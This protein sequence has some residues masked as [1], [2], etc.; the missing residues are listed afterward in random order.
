MSD[1]ND[2][3]QALSVN[4]AAT[5]IIG[6]LIGSIS[7]VAG[8]AVVAIEVVN[9]IENQ[10]GPSLGDVEAALVNMLDEIGEH[11]RSMDIQTRITNIKQ[12]LAPAVTAAVDQLPSN[13]NAGLDFSDQQT[14]IAD[15]LNALNKLSDPS[16]LPLDPINNPLWFVFSGDPL[17]WNDDPDH[18][19][20]VQYGKTI[21]DTVQ[22]DLG[23]SLQAP[24]AYSNTD[25]VFNHTY[26]LISYLQGFA[27]L[28]AVGLALQPGFATNYRDSLERYL[29]FLLAVH[30]QIV[31]GIVT[32]VP[33][34]RDAFGHSTAVKWTGQSLYI[35]TG[36]LTGATSGP[37]SSNY[38]VGV[39]NQPVVPGTQMPS[40]ATIEYGAIEIYSGA[41]VMASYV[42]D[43]DLSPFPDLPPA[44]G[45]LSIE[46]TDDR[47]YRKFTLRAE[48]KL[49]RV[50]RKFG[51]MA[52]RDAI[53]SGRRLLGK[54]ALGRPGPGDWSFRHIAAVVGPSALIS[55][56]GGPAKVISLKAIQQFITQVV[57]NDTPF[58]AEMFTI[59]FSDILNLQ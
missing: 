9:L 26:I 54:P 43:F 8:A 25:Q 24:A 36:A 34:R 42:V 16:Q 19:V 18:L 50:Y 41:S 49:H 5:A 47:P 1:I 35:A 57:P 30:D 55:Q 7:T 31:S 12:T 20:D 11:L 38:L 52:L 53:D 29:D 13:V 33:Q 14:Q 39:T 59:S 27:Y 10:S 45:S 56:P 37:P 46:S 28:L 6:G 32:L 51:T 58:V 23:Y 44:V 22:L 17:Y 3:A 2:L 21:E 4:G 48:S 40:G 15:C